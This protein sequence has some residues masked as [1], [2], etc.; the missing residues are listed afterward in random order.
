MKKKQKRVKP[1]IISAVLALM[2][3][4]SLSIMTAAPT[5]ATDVGTPTTPGDPAVTVQQPAPV[6]A[7]RPVQTTYY[8]V[9]GETITIP[10]VYDLL[11]GSTAQ[12]VFTWS[13]SSNPD[14]NFISVNQNGQVTGLKLSHPAAKVKVMSD[15]GLFRE[16]TINVVKKAV[17]VVDVSVHNPPKK[18]SIGQTKYLKTVVNPSNATNCF[19]KYSLDK[20][21]AKYVS[22]DKSGKVT[23]IAKGTANIKVKAGGKSTVVTIKVI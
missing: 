10:F 6:V 5:F 18:I 4:M 1:R 8:I 23:A 7:M 17:K 3:G 19:I 13:I 12:P 2:V 22:V 15:N 9:K 21:S 11:P 20:K 16:F 14:Y